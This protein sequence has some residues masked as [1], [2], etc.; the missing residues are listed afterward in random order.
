MYIF[1][2]IKRSSPTFL[3]NTGGDILD[4][5]ELSGRK[6]SKVARGYLKE[7]SIAWKIQVGGVSVNTASCTKKTI[8]MKKHVA[9]QDP[10]DM[11]IIL[12]MNSTSGVSIKFK[13]CRNIH[14]KVHK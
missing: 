7:V 5:Q 9:D 1:Y 13:N 6:S 10:V 8:K 3:V 12:D 11:P 14:V 2:C 4:L